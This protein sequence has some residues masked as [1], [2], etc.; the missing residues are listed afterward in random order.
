MIVNDET[1]AV[2]SNISRH[3]PEFEVKKAKICLKPN[4]YDNNK[5][6]RAKNAVKLYKM[7]KILT[8]DFIIDS[9]EFQS[10]L[11]NSKQPDQLSLKCD[12]E[13][14]VLTNHIGK[15]KSIL[16]DSFAL[17][18]FNYNDKIEYCL[19]DTYD[20]YVEENKS[21]A[22]LNLKVRDV[23]EV[24]CSVNFHACE[25]LPSSKVPWLAT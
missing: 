4:S 1:V 2:S 21:A 6:D 5:V 8:P 12:E 16:S 22:Q 11:G 24:D 19:C 18:Q 10:T 23:I 3:F 20:F 9:G 14:K 7:E 17:L 25:I 15:V 13:V